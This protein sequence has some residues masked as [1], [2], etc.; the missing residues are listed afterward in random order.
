[1]NDLLLLADLDKQK[2][3]H[4]TSCDLVTGG[5]GDTGDGRCITCYSA[6]NNHRKLAK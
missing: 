1:M 6:Q 5:A 3:A 4:V 2:L